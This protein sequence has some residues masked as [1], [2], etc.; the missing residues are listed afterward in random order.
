[1]D[2]SYIGKTAT[3]IDD[4]LD[5]GLEAIILDYHEADNT[6]DIKVLLPNDRKRIRKIHGECLQVNMPEE[7]IPSAENV[8]ND[9]GIF[10]VE[11]IYSNAMVQKREE[12][13]VRLPGG[14][15]ADNTP[16]ENIIALMGTEEAEV[17]IAEMFIEA[18]KLFIEKHKP[19]PSKSVKGSWHP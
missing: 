13:S 18:L 9:P 15:R 17:K 11:Q 16:T 19:E 5:K 1:M 7:E 4:P 2:K 10:E 14:F 3:I 12:P 8:Q 6:C